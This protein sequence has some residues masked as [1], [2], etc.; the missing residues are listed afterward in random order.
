ML[1]L[2][3]HL[4][5]PMS[6]TMVK[7]IYPDGSPCR[8]C[9]EAVSLLKDRG[10]WSEI[11]KEVLADPNDPQGEGMK[12]VEEY[13]VK[14]APFFIVEQDGNV[15]VYKSVLK[16]IKEKFAKGLMPK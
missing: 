6:I 2:A 5:S 4:E 1:R 3:I 10:Y 11:T 14:V 8:K 13:E 9:E 15:K 12:L 7:K 16:L